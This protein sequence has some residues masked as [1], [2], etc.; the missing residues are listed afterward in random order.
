M[1]AVY[2]PWRGEY[3]RS[4]KPGGCIFCKSSLRRGDYILWEGKTAYV[5]MNRYPY[6]CGHLM[7]IPLRHLGQ[8]PEFTPEEKLEIFDLVDLSV[9]VLKGAMKPDGFNIG[10][11]LGRVAG[12]GVDDHLHIHLVPRWNGDT[13]FMT[14][15]GETRVISEDLA[16]TRDKLIPL[17]SQYIS[18]GG[19]K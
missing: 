12:A 2:A 1:E 10:M 16:Q 8:L 15:T 19:L 4:E 3:V 18:S 7:V 14:V 9:T 17:F 6:T 5:M 13:N 11:N